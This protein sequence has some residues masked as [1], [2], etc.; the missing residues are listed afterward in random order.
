MRR[1]ASA[2]SVSRRVRRASGLRQ[3][4]QQ[5]ARRFVSRAQRLA[6]TFQRRSRRCEACGDGVVG[7]RLGL[8]D[9]GRRGDL[10]RDFLGTHREQLG[11]LLTERDRLLEPQP[12]FSERTLARLRVLEDCAALGRHALNGLGAREHHLER[13][14]R[15]G[16]LLRAL[17]VPRSRSSQCLLRLT[18]LVLE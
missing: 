16:E 13:T 5:R 18:Q 1:S 17:V 12:F 15:G 3:R 6:L 7:D 11:P 10:G 9:R 8:G 2:S 14:A 4:A